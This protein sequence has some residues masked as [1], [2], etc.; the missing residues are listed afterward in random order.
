MV[1]EFLGVMAR[2]AWAGDQ[3]CVD[4][5]IIAGIDTISGR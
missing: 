1:S 2:L 3:P 4:R 5:Y